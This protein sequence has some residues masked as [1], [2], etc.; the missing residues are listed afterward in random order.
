MCLC[1]YCLQAADVTSVN[2]TLCLLLT[3]FMCNHGDGVIPTDDV[4]RQRSLSRL[5]EDESSWLQPVMTFVDTLLHSNR[6]D[7]RYLQETFTLIDNLFS[8]H[9]GNGSYQLFLRWF[10][11]R[12]SSVAC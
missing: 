2:I 8:L 1:V 3:Y 4:T 6:R 11:L 12:S 10:V 7:D 5:R 9:I